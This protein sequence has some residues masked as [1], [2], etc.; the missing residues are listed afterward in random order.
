MTIFFSAFIFILGASIGSF[1]NVLIDRLPFEKSIGGRS[2]CDHCHHQLSWYDLIPIISFF[3]LKGK[4]RYCHKKISC[5]YPL[6]EFLT[7][8][9]FVFTFLYFSPIT[10]NNF[11][12]KIWQL[13]GYWGIISCLIVIFFADLKYQL[14]PDQI[15]I[16]F[17]VFSLILIPF[18]SNPLFYS[19]LNRVFA[20]FLVIMPIFLIYFLS[21]EK[22]MGFGDVKLA[23]N[24]GFL[25]GVKGGFLALYFGFIFG[26]LVGLIL[27]LL[28]R[29]KLKSKIAFGPF[30]VL[31]ILIMMF[32][33][34]EIFR[35]IS[36]FYG[37]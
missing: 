8:V 28:K 37:L 3:I 26:G 25:L 18:N 19:F 29:K 13:V 16:A 10:K 9:F 35:L 27:I 15:Q 23:F 22:A 21:N 32:W 6:I 30:L 5:Y 34:N 1:L 17:F 12:F 4:C 2:I 24:I 33:Q 36:N 11:H 20:S 7:A 14:I 31:G